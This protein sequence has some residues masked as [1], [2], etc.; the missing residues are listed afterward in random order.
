L[1]KTIFIFFAE[2]KDKKKKEKNQRVLGAFLKNCLDFYIY[3]G[4]SSKRDG[5]IR[6]SP[7]S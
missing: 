5:E 7:V 2:K 1:I 3:D 6:K 4:K